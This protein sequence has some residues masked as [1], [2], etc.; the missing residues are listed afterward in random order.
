M[1]LALKFFYASNYSLVP[2]GRVRKYDRISTVFLVKNIVQL[3]P[4]LKLNGIGAL[5]SPKQLCMRSFPIL[6]VFP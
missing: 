5:L 1:I 6:M 2:L 4:P 3:V